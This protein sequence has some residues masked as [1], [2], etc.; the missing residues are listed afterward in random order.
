MSGV[1]PLPAAPPPLPGETAPEDASSLPSV[2]FRLWEPFAVFAFV[3]VTAGLVSIAIT[4]ATKGDLEKALLVASFEVVLGAWTIG[5]VRLAHRRGTEAL[6]ARWDGFVSQIRFGLAAGAVGWVLSTLVVGSV[7]LWI[8]SAL[9][10]GEVESPDQLDYSSPGAGILALTAVGVVLVAPI[11]EE[12][13]F[14][15]LVFGAF[16]SRLRFVPAAV[17][18]GALFMLAHAPF[19]L[20]LP[21]ILTLGVVLA[22]VYQRRGSIVPCIVGH[23]L[24]NAIGFAAYLVTR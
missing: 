23:A 14:R 15:G 6:G 10:T 12:L 8:V 5:W 2:P 24:F 18:S 16:R 17:V 13:F 4:A 21:S 9:S 3:F 1:P 19:W 20:I 11:A 7:V 22:W